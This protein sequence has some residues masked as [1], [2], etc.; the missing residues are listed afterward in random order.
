MKSITVFTPTFNRAYCLGQLY[1]SLVNQTNQDFTWMIVDDGS[2]DK[3]NELVQSWINDGKIEI[4]YIYKE[5]GGMHSAHNTA[6]KNIITE[7]NVCIDSDDY[8]P[9]NAIEKIIRLWD[10]KK[11]ENYA[12]IIGL[13]SDKNGA[14]IGS[15]IPDS[16][17]VSTMNDLYQKHKVFG[18]K[19]LVLRTE[20]VKQYPLYPLYPNEKLVPLGTL[21]LMIDQNYKYLCSNDVYCIVEYL[22]DGS[23]NNILK[24]YKQ[25]PRGFAYSRLV[26]M[27]YSKS[28]SYSFTRAIHYMSS[29]LFSRKFNFFGGN[30]KKAITFLAIPF[31]L[32]FHLYL[33]YKIKR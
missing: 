10:E 31:G 14:V 25:S 11:E 28:F 27:K 1:S 6:Y 26:E 4:Q 9:T 29:C 13:D 17:T 2:K 32:A 19:K 30:P 20:V 3:T 18:D 5:N 23:S 7:L 12:G 16:V 21:Y 24:Q 33:R 15:K 22:P 8:M